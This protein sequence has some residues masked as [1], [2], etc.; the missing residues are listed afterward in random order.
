MNKKIKLL[1]TYLDYSKNWALG[2]MSILIVS[3]LGIIQLPANLKYSKE[4]WTLA[5]VILTF[6]MM[7]IHFAFRYEKRQKELVKAIK[8]S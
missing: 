2:S 1:E 3:S 5:I 4:W 8:E 7:S 6:A